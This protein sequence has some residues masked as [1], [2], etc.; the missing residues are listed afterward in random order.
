MALN[1]K[2]PL[3]TSV[4]EVFIL[5]SHLLSMQ[6]LDRQELYNR[7]R[8]GEKST[9]KWKHQDVKFFSAAQL[10]LNF[11]IL[12]RF[13]SPQDQLHLRY[14]DTFCTKRQSLHQSWD[15]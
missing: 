14:V 10:I 2:R 5:L 4:S 1:E 6:Q 15:P 13:V 7:M 12:V 9:C 11:N 8:F 3:S